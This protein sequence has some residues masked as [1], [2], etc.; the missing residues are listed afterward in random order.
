MRGENAEKQN[1][2]SAPLYGKR[3]IT[4][5]LALVDAGLFRQHNTLN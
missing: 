4:V 3:R 2:L 1:V 5:D